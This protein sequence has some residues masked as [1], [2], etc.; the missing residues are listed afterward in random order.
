MFL[1][2]CLQPIILYKN[3]S[4]SIIGCVTNNLSTLKTKHQN[5]MITNINEAYCTYPFKEK[6]K[7]IKI[8]FVGDT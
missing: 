3:T 1:L 7:E 6:K 2:L 4:T 5:M 8:L